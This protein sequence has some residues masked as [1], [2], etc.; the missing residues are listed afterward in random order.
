LKKTTPIYRARSDLLKNRIFALL[1][2]LP[3]LVFSAQGQDWNSWK[4]ET[5]QEL[6]KIVGWCT[7]E[8]AKAIMEF[9]YKERPLICVEIGAFGGSTTFPIARS[10]QFIGR[11]KVWAIDAW[12]AQRAAGA[13]SHDSPDFTWWSQVDMHRC[14]LEFSRLMSQKSLKNCCC[15]AIRKP[16]QDA[17]HLFS[18]ESIDFLYLDGDSSEEGSLRDVLLYFPKVK[19]G[20]FIWI[21]D[22]DYDS[23]RESVAYLMDRCEWI[24]EFSISNTSI[25]LKKE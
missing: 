1:Y 20:G 19:T 22:A 3:C 21:N 11:G 24:K 6:P 4:L 17:V 18:D 25:L 7:A 23:K 13:F 16:S 12:D 8:R 10:I 14:Y 15:C 9:M 5:V 2:L